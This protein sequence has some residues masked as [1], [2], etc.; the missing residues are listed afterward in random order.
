M[1]VYK[2]NKESRDFLKSLY[3]EEEMNFMISRLES[4]ANEGI[5]EGENSFS[6]PSEKT[7]IGNLYFSSMDFD[8]VNVYDEDSWNSYP[9]VTP[10]KGE[11]FMVFVTRK[12]CVTEP[13]VGKTFQ[14]SDVLYIH[15]GYTWVLI[16]MSR[17]NQVLYKKMEVIK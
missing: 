13:K 14:D 2:L 11:L 6:V 8:S 15:N 10:P 5:P 4:M 9:E 12:D 17:T 7:H 3:C 16:D 1:K